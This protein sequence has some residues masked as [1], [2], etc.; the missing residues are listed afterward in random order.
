MCGESAV[1]TIASNWQ[2]YSTA[3]LEMDHPGREIE[4]EEVASREALMVLNKRL[5]PSGP[6]S[7][8]PAVFSFVEVYATLSH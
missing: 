5:R 7:R 6:G 8:Q 3:L 2:K 1:P 4:D